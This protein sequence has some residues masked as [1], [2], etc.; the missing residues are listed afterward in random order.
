M[1]YRGYPHKLR[2]VEYIDEP[3]E[4]RY[5]EFKD[6]LDDEG[7]EFTSS[8]KSNSDEWKIDRVALASLVER[9][10]ALSPADKKKEAF[11]GYTKGDLER[12]LGVWVKETD[13]KYKKVIFVSWRECYGYADHGGLF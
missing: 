4:N 13:P 5:Q 12:T 8:S 9:L 10:A 6:Y 7:V 3:I 11:E 1:D 2:K